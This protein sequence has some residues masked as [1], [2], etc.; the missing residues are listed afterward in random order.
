MHLFQY[1]GDQLFCEDMPVKK[2]A[3]QVGTPFYLYSLNTLSNHF[4][5]FDDAFSAVPHI[6]CFSLKSNSNLGILS[7]FAGLGGGADIMSGGELYRALRAGFSPKKITYAGPG[8]TPEEIEYA[9]KNNILMFNLESAQEAECINKVAGKLGKKARV[10]FRVNPDVDPRTHP[11]ISTGLKENKFGINIKKAMAEFKKANA[12]KNLDVAG[13]HEHIGSQITQIKPFTDTVKRVKEFIKELKAEGINIRYFDMGGGL[14]ITYKDEKPPHPRE[15]ANAV[16]PI[17]N[18]LDCT[19]IFEPGRVIVGNAGILV[20]KVLYT[21]KS[22]DKNFVIV[23]AAMNDLIRPSLYGSY[24]EII[25]VAK[26]RGAGRMVVDIVGPICE[27]G[28]F[29]AK[30]RKIQP[31]RQGDLIAVMSAGAYGFTMSSNYNSRLRVPEVIVRGKKF[32]IARKRETYK[33][34]VRGERRLEL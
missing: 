2:I 15:L 30:K 31:L 29:L 17:L 8:K 1:N 27:S 20:S 33:D 3:E 6:T 24:Q 26:R 13:V 16:I 21:K 18:G 10:A 28:D 25:P 9:L 7:I 5:A 22:E 12:M 4:K 14:G 11:Y 19:F 34:L 32:C 23:D